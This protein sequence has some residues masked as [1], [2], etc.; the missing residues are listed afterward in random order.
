MILE[1]G[2]R[3]DGRSNTDIR[4][5]TCEVGVLPRA[6]GSALFTRGETQSLVST[7]LGTSRDE[8]MMDTME[9]ESW[10]I[11]KSDGARRHIES[12]LLASMSSEIFYIPKVAENPLPVAFKLTRITDTTATFEN[13]E[14]DFPTKIVYMRVDANAM[15]VSVEGAAN[16]G[17]PQRE[18]SVTGSNAIS[19][20]G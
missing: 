19:D 14:H 4:E 15:T 16:D 11:A 6:H 12:M 3:V 17:E 1:S 13:P 9:G 10:S 5:V 18:H 20:S 8:Q 2:V 7:T